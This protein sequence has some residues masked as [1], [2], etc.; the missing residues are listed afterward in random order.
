MSAVV[1]RDGMSREE[2]S[3]LLFFETCEVDYG[4]LVKSECMNADDF[5]IA[6]RWND[7]GYVR[8]GRVKAN[9]IQKGVPYPRNRW[10]AL[11]ESAWADAHALRRERAKR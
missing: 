2:K 10:C 1:N 4:G 9:D 8:F 6:D 3:L 11:S 7:A 5:E